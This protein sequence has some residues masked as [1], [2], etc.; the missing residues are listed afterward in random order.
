MITE[1]EINI[2]KQ[3]KKQPIDVY[4]HLLKAPY[5]NRSSPKRFFERNYLLAYFR[6]FTVYKK[7]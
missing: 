3:Q 1:I 5:S 2:R 7:I 6:G 4:V